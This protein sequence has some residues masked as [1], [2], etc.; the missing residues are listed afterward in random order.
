MGDWRPSTVMPIT[1]MMAW[2]PGGRTRF[3]AGSSRPPRK[4][5]QQLVL[6]V[7]L[8]VGA[9]GVGIWQLVKA[10]GEAGEASLEA[11]T[12]ALET[13]A[14]VSTVLR[15][16]VTRDAA[17]LAEFVRGSEED[18]EAEEEDAVEEPEV[19]TAEAPP[20]P[21]PVRRREPPTFAPVPTSS[22]GSSVIAA[23]PEFP[24]LPGVF[25]STS[26]GVVPPGTENVRLRT[27]EPA[28]VPVPEGLSVRVGVA[29]REP[30]RVEV[31][32]SPYGQVERAK[33]ISAP[34]DIHE[35]MILS[36]IK[37]W[38]FTPAVKDGHPVR[39]RLVLPIE[40]ALG[41]QVS[42]RRDP[43]VSPSDR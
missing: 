12:G 40:V 28:G 29:P 36:A 1:E 10:S 33:L 22:L 11:L 27:V 9:L 8:L 4:R 23:P 2:P 32:V 24:P 39:Y 43:A 3:A 25:D 34:E 35:A 13:A 20:R 5:T 38:Q 15:E 21:A 16:N 37:A 18:D 41:G 42:P 14:E 30:S 19:T 7:L 26:P 17:R 31:I 6:I